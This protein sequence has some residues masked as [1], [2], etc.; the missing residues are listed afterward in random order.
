MAPEMIV[1]AVAANTKW[2]KK[3]GNY[4]SD[5]NDPTQCL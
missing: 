3:S 1:A 5:M 4:A 2:K